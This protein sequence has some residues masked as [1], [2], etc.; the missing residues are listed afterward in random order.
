M[1]PT[2]QILSLSRRLLILG[3]LLVCLIFLA[4][5][6]P[7]YADACSDCTATYNNHVNFCYSIL[8]L[9]QYLGGTSCESLFET[10]WSNSTVAYYNCQSNSCVGGGVVGGGRES[11]G[12]PPGWRTACV[13]GCDEVYSTCH[14]NGGAN[15]G[16]YQS[17]VASGVDSDDCCYLERV[18]CLGGC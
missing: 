14:D 3:V 9:C 7:V 4:S 5:Q 11:G 6:R 12:D 1:K 8:N 10:C 18:I 17:C 13:Q 16:S 15:T 2:I